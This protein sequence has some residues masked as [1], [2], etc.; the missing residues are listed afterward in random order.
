MRKYMPTVEAVETIKFVKILLPRWKEVIGFLSWTTTMYIEAKTV[1][2]M[3]IEYMI[4]LDM[5]IFLALDRR[6]VAFHVHELRN[7]CH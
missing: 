7:G 5:Y 6:S 1:Y 4:R 2:I 3:I